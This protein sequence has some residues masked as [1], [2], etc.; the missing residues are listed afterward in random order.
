MSL[1]QSVTGSTLPSSLIPNGQ[2][3]AA[4]LRDPSFYPHLTNSISTPVSSSTDDSEPQD[5]NAG[6]WNSAPPNRPIPSTS[7]TQ[8]PLTYDPHPDEAE[9]RL[10]L[11]RTEMLPNFACM[12]LASDISAQALRQTRP[13]LLQVIMVVTSTS[14]QEKNFLATEF[15]KTVV[16]DVYILN[17]G[18]FDHLLALLV[19][20][21]W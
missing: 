5:S 4:T 2:S 17:R 1:L 13:V 8:P 20:L 15:L 10:T 3:S 12:N 18:H 21:A 16:N 7:Y 6:S 9:S 19:F 14:M 11:F